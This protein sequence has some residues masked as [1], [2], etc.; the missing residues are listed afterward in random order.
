MPSF[1]KKDLSEQDICSKFILLITSKY[2]NRN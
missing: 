1:N 2:E